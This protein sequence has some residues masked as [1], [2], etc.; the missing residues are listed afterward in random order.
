MI[1]TPL[2]SFPDI[3]A[4]QKISV[5]TPIFFAYYKYITR[6]LTAVVTASKIDQAFTF[7]WNNVCSC[8]IQSIFTKCLHNPSDADAWSVQAS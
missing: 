2:E 8:E 4:V 7:C 1:D 3:E 6:T 5:L